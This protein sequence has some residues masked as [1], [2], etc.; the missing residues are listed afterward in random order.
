MFEDIFIRFIRNN[1]K[2]KMRR[3]LEKEINEEAQAHDKAMKSLPV[4]EEGENHEEGK[5]GHLDFGIGAW[6]NRLRALG[7]YTVQSCE[8]GEGHAYKYPTINFKGGP[9]EG[10]KVLNYCIRRR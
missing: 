2:D 1:H 9:G 10:W 6:V 3:E 7:V 4:L 5:Y 8:G